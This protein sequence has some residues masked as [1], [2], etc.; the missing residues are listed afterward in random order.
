MRS[1]LVLSPLKIFNH[2]KILHTAY[3]IFFALVICKRIHR[4][5]KRNNRILKQFVN[6]N[7]RL[8]WSICF[9]IHRPPAPW[10]ILNW[11]VNIKCLKNQM[12]HFFIYEIFFF[13]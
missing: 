2:V 10:C 4:K 7:S 13:V 9:S 6:Q 12:Q 1:K 5:E 11:Y 3:R 8:S